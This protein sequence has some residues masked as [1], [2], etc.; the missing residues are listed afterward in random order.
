VPANY[1]LN[2]IVNLRENEDILLYNNILAISP[3]EEQE[4]LVF[5]KEEY[6][7]EATGH[8]YQSPAFSEDAAVWAAKTIYTAAQLMLFRENKDADLAALLP[9]FKGAQ[10]SSEIISADLCLRFLPD[11]LQQLKLMDAEDALIAV[12]EGIL[13]RW[14][15]SG[16]N[17]PLDVNTL[18]LQA[19]PGNACLQQL[20]SN[21]IIAYK[22]I[23]LAKHPAFS[24]WIAA[25]LG[26]YAPE[27]WNEFK[28]EIN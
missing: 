15:F 5:L 23:Q 1:F 16:V 8:P 9:G 11:M 19:M 26:L 25:S 14:H 24:P 13:M 28:Q 4:V 2:M 20:Y 18:D 21:R 6:I 17:Y 27:L 22:K 10:G 3:Q 7:A 12:L